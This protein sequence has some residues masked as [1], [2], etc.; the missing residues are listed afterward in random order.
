MALPRLRNPRRD[1]T[2][3]LPD[4][5][6]ARVLEPSPPSNDDPG[7]YADDP[8]DPSGESGAVVVSPTSDGDVTWDEFVVDRPHLAGFAADH[9]LG[10]RRRL[11]RL[12]DTFETTRRSLHRLAFFVMAPARYRA[13][14]KLGLRFTALGFGTPFF[15]EDTQIRAEGTTLVKQGVDVVRSSDL[16][17]LAEAARFL[18]LE[19]SDVW[20]PDFHDPLPPADPHAD[21]DIDA[22]AASA[23]GDW[24]GFATGVLEELRRTDGATRAVYGGSPGDDAHPEPYLYVAPS[25]SPHR[26]DPFWN[27]D[28]FAGASLPYEELVAADDP[29]GSARD[30]FRRARTILTAEPQG[31]K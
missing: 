10:A 5:H 22:D 21:L 13:T 23:L 26:S 20:F 24:F 15:G 19:Y 25:S 29:F 8:T 16:S 17:T 14:G 18:D 4:G 6:V 27:D 11:R 2:D 30:F 3:L 1:A 12:S 31:R 7:W 9:W 28:R